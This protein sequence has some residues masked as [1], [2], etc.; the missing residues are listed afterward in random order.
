LLIG[1]SHVGRIAAELGTAHLACGLPVHDRI[2]AALQ[3]T[4]GYRG[5]TYF[6]AEAAN[7]LLEHQAHHADYALHTK[8]TAW[9]DD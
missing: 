9:I 4:V 6:L 7:R 1:S 8:R 3:V 5:G 2:G